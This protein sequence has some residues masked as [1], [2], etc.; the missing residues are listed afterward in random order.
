MRPQRRRAGLRRQPRLSAD[1]S[2]HPINYDAAGLMRVFDQMPRRLR[3][4][5]ND[6]GLE[7]DIYDRL[8]L[9][10]QFRIAEAMSPNH[11]VTQ[12]DLDDVWRD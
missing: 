4:E 11:L 6:R 10:W 8:P 7:Q 5:I 2:D 1:Y 3:D 9:E 12:A